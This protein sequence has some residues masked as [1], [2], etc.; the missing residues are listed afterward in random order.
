MTVGTVVPAGLGRHQPRPLAL[1]Q[2]P[3]LR[4]QLGGAIPSPEGAGAGAQ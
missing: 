2:V 3:A 1:P 4:A